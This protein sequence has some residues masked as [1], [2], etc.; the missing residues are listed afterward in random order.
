MFNYPDLTEY[1]RFIENNDTNYH[2]YAKIIK[3]DDIYNLIDVGNFNKIKI[4]DFFNK[5]LITNISSNNPSGLDGYITINNRYLIIGG[6]DGSIKEFDIQQR[7][8][9]KSFD[10]QHSNNA[11]GIKIINDKNGKIYLVSY[12][13][14]KNMF[15][16]SL[17]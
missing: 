12:G 10:K 14:G 11:L 5:T 13:D 2:N 15:L 17:E 1:Y 3:I 4:W 6:K 9:I 7:T 16:W 8:F